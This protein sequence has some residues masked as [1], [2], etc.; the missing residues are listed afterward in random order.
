MKK[1]IL[2]S[3]ILSSAI[4]FNACSNG[5]AA[6]AQKQVVSFYKVPLVCSAAPDIGCGSRSKPV[7]LKLEKNPSVKE[8][9]LNRAGTVI[10]IVWKNNEQ[11][12][13][14]A[15]PVFNENGVDFTEISEKDATDY[16]ENFRK[17]NFWYHSADVDMLSREEAATIA[18]S[19]VKWSLEN[20]LITPDETNKIKAD[21]EAYF[22]EEL[23]KLRTREQLNDDSQNKFREALY[24]IAE[25]I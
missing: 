4:A 6:T 17:E 9:W 21:V 12:E 16:K 3:L 7:L 18:A 14:V 5:N 20:N 19:L 10:A 23:V 22:K 15:K 11:T 1:T 24:N 2:L 8:A 25:N 13:T